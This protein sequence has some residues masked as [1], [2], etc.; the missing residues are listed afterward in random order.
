MKAIKKHHHYTNIV[1][2]KIIFTKI[3]RNQALSEAQ[4]FYI[5]LLSN[6]TTVYLKN[7]HLAV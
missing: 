5:A 2:K 6:N 7:Q 3:K 1:L 4:E